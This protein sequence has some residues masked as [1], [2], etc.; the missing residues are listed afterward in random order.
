MTIAQVSQ[1]YGLSQDTLRYY[2]R[3]GLLPRVNRSEGGKRDY[4][5]KDLKWVEFI[6]CMRASGI[7]VEAL[8]EYVTLFQQGDSTAE[9]RKAILIG[10]RDALATRV[11][12]LSSTLERLTN[13]IAAYDRR[14]ALREAELRDIQKEDDLL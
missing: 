8:I 10:E 14:L 9:A 4:L 1:Q 3:I 5:E 7:S 2:E 12:E 13:K 11:S 6:K